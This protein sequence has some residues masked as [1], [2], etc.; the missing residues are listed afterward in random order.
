MTDACDAQGPAHGVQDCT[1]QWRCETKL[2]THQSGNLMCRAGMI[3]IRQALA[4]IIDQEPTKKECGVVARGPLPPS[5]EWQSREWYGRPRGQHAHA[6]A[7]QCV[8][9]TQIECTSRSTSLKARKN[10]VKLWEKVNEPLSLRRTVAV[11]AW[12]FELS[13]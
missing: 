10:D 5:R 6:Q 11:G 2:P 7:H 4:I 13:C 12:F 3:S 9:P 8:I 1:G